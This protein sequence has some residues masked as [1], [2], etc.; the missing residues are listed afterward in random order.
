MGLFDKKSTF[1]RFVESI[2]NVIADNPTLDENFMEE[3]EESLVMS[4]IGIETSDKIMTALKEIIN[5][6]YIT[7]P[8]R[9]KEELA[10][11]I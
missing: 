5:K 10:L 8:E 9:I 4:D 7:R 1:R 2:T 11:V 3:L 6:R